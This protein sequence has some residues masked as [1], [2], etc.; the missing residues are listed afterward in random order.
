MNP[1]D[2]S[3]VRAA[4]T[5]LGD[6]PKGAQS[7]MTHI[8]EQYTS[9]CPE[10]KQ[11]GI[12][13]WFAWDRD[14]Q[15]PF[16]KSVHCVNCGADQQGPADESDTLEKNLNPTTGL[17][18]HVA[19][20]R[21]AAQDESIRSRISELVSL[22]TARN[23]S[24]LMDIIHRL[25][26][27]SPLPDV[28]RVLTALV[29]DALDQGS[30][31]VPYGNEDI[32]PKSLRPSKLFLEYNIWDRMENAMRIYASQTQ[33]RPFAQIP[34]PSLQSFLS[35][36]RGYILIA[37]TLH[38]V[39]SRLPSQEIKLVILH[40]EI[41]EVAYRALSSLWST[42]LWKSE[43]LPAALRAFMGRRRLDPDWHQRDLK[44][45]LKNLEPALHEH[46]KI[47]CPSTSNAI[48]DLYNILK[49]ARELNYDVNNWLD[50]GAEGYRFIFESS[51][52][53]NY[54]LTLTPEQHFVSTLERRGEPSSLQRLKAAYLVE[55]PAAD[56]HNLPERLSSEFTLI[57]DADLV[58]LQTSRNAQQPLADRVEETILHLL[59]KQSIWEREL[60]EEEIYAQYNGVNSPEPE[61]INVCINAYTVTN[62]TN[63]LS[64]RPED[65]PKTRR[66]ELRD[67]RT[68]I[69]QLG[70]HL[71]FT[72]G[73]R[74]NSDIVWKEPG[75]VP[76]L[77]RFSSTALLTPHLLNVS[78]MRN[79][80]RRCLVLPGGRASL[81]A[82]KLRRDPRLQQAIIRNN[83]VFIKFRHLRRM[84][85]EIKHRGEIDFY[86]GL[87]PIVEKD[88]AQIPLPLE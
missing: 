56:M 79:S 19:L 11:Q 52:A 27:A 40:P 7:L 42:W 18:Y 47:L 67:S 49:C 21:A 48:P 33:L 75:K 35:N 39:I 74:L 84:L 77:F 4:L 50:T 16:F 70:I 26:S 32:R 14:T 8:N 82:L 44:T 63:T 9:L 24:A 45:T 1:I 64:L 68:Q 58:W 69:E 38:S 23:L 15:Q 54:E 55:E 25:P 71:G 29:I 59:Q 86:L 22:Y 5:K 17:A 46:A 80:E 66:A 83:W 34:A 12:A 13:R 61:L 31:L 41:P 2:P 6:S 73:R 10:C 20:E 87:D 65:T 62:L 60:L 36:D 57:E 51:S 37:N 85:A 72:V 76:Y 43:R 78:R 3:Q 81:V 28:R 53:I 88:S 30:N